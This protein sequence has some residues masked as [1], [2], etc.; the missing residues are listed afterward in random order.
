MKIFNDKPDGNESADLE[1]ARY[2]NVAIEQIIKITDWMK[3]ADRAAQPLLFHID[4]FVY[5]AEKYP[6]MA[7]R[8]IEKLDLPEIKKTF[9]EWFERANS[10]IPQKLRA[11]IK[12]SADQLFLKLEHIAND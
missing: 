9:Y 3:T 11:G 4:M 7:S 8:R 12:S 10:Q 5:L 2:F 1:P 6:D